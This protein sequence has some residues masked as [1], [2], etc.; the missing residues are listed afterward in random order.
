MKKEEFVIE[1][2]NI[3]VEWAKLHE[4]ELLNYESYRWTGKTYEDSVN[5]RKMI[6]A[7][8]RFSR[9]RNNGGID[10]AI[11]DRIYLWGFG[12]RFP[13]RD[14]DEVI[15]ATKEAF[16]FLDKGDCYQA[17]KRLM[18]IDGVGVAG[19]TKLLGLSDQE[20][21][22]IYDS[23]V[24]YALKDLTKHG[25]RII[26]CPPGRTIKGDYVPP[27]VADYVWSE[28]YEKFI[29]ILEIIRDYLKE[30]SYAL[31]IGD[32]ETALF[33]KGRQTHEP[34]LFA[35]EIKLVSEE[36]DPP[37]KCELCN[38]A[39]KQV[40]QCSQCLKIVCNECV[41]PFIGICINCVRDLFNG[42]AVCQLCNAVRP[43]EKLE[44]CARCGRKACD[45]DFNKTIEKCIDC[46]DRAVELEFSLEEFDFTEEAGEDEEARWPEESNEY[47]ELD[48]GPDGYEEVWEI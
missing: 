39:V 43:I 32:I 35:T 46:A 42:N 4:K 12:T 20:N 41:D 34:I 26:L 24:G 9:Q 14:E 45:S 11:A 44:I 33:M 29:W 21:L 30:K 13:L 37:E 6:E 31:R 40:L 47:E 15:E 1:F 25:K 3:I 8:I 36:E 17:C 22:G 19:A 48:E 18:W 38:S 27:N 5:A 28:N 7:A 2:K 23:R 10:L 16:E